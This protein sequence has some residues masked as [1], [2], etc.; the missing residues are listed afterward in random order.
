MRILR[1]LSVLVMVT[2]LGGCYSLGLNA[3]S[4]PKPISLSNTIGVP[5]VVVRH[6]RHEAITW[7]MGGVVPYATL[8]GHRNPWM[9]ADKLVLSLCHEELVRSG[10]GIV[11]LQLTQQHTFVSLVLGAVPGLAINLIP[12]MPPLIGTLVALGAQPVAVVIEGDVVKLK[13]QSAAPGTMRLADG[14]LDTAGVDVRA[15][16]ESIR[17][18]L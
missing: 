4:Y 6:F 1:F 7:Y 13:G 18:A 14:R 3:R 8:P 16:V 2:L 11:N 10:D 5:S 9:P 12:G 17:P 15:L